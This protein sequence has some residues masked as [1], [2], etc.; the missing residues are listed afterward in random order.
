MSYPD[1]SCRLCD[2]KGGTPGLFA[3]KARIELVIHNKYE[4]P[5]A[6]PFPGW[7]RTKVICASKKLDVTTEFS[8]RAVREAKSEILL[9]NDLNNR[10]QI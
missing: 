10:D 3:F 1:R 5:L 7:F 9:S 4:F 8:M 6:I 2:V